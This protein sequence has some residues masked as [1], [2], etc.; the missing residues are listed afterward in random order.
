[1]PRHPSPLSRRAIGSAI[2]LLLSSQAFADPVTTSTL[3]W[4][5]NGIV[6]EVARAGDVAYVGGSFGTV[7]PSPNLVYGFAAFATD[8]AVPVS[9]SYTHLTLPT[10][11]EV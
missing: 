4:A 7:A 11:R 9:V 1:M 6:S 5:V 8:S 10:N 3:G 2:A